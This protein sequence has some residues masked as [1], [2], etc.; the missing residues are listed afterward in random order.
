MTLKPLLV[1]A[2]TRPD[3]IDPIVVRIT[4]PRTVVRKV[5]CALDSPIHLRIVDVKLCEVNINTTRMLGVDIICRAF[6]LHWEYYLATSHLLV[7]VDALAANNQFATAT[8]IAQNMIPCN[9]RV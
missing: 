1:L 5:H 3:R 2:A 8:R 7:V 4:F 9:G 6:E